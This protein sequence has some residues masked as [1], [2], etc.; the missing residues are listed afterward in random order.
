MKAKLLILLTFAVVFSAYSQN[1][2]DLKGFGKIPYTKTNDNYL[3]TINDFGSFTFIGTVQPLNL[4]AKVT[5]EQLKKFPGYEVLKQLELVEVGLKLSSE[6]LNMEAKADTKKKL[7]TVCD[8][9]QIT[10]PY[11]VLEAEVTSNSF[12][13]SGALDFSDKPIVINLNQETGTRITLMKFS[14]GA[15]IEADMGFDAVL[16]VK[17]EVKFRPTI[18]DPDLNTVLE[19][20]FNLLTLELTGAASLTDTWQDPLGLSHYIGTKKED[21]VIS[22]AAVELGWVIGS[23]TPTNIGFVVDEAKLFDI[24]WGMLISMNPTEGEIALQASTA[25]ITMEQ[26]ENILNKMGLSLPP[27]VMPKGNDYYVDDALILFAPNGGSVGEFEIEKGFAMRGGVNFGG[28]VKG[29]LDFFANLNDGFSFEMGMDVKELFELL[30]EE[31]ENVNDPTIR[32]A[33]NTAIGTLRLNSIRLLLSASIENK[34]LAGGVECE[35]VLFEKDVK[36]KR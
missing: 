20:S 22:N 7:K 1:S 5:L 14:I 28:M 27:N 2:I 12:E 23:P 31:I 11:I 9:L 18:H 33:L 8:A 17:N 15:E 6:G 35:M 34:T 32:D 30:E 24:Q 4:E 13:M 21:F 3:V 19:M 16:Y 29:D 10:A 36:L 26:L 25:K